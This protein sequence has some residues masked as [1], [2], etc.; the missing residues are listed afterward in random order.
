MGKDIPKDL[1]GKEAVLT[2]LKSQYVTQVIVNGS[3]KALST[4]K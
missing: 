4:S 1:K 3:K 2:I